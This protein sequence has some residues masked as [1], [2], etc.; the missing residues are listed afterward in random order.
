MAKKQDKLREGKIVETPEE[1]N[2]DVYIPDDS[3]MMMNE[4]QAFH[5]EQQ[6]EIKE[7]IN[8]DQAMF[9]GN[10]ALVEAVFEWMENERKSSDSIATAR[11]IA[12]EYNITLEQALIV[13]DTIAKTFE[14]KK[15]Q[16]QNIYDT[17]NKTE[18]NS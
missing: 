12:K 15:V 10:D 8:E 6:E 17:I 1:E 16:F 13:C 5:E 2:L 7:E 18:T 4:G 14:F 3:M 9:A 11:A